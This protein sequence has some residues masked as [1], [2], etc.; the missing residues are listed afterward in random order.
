MTRTPLLWVVWGLIT[1]FGVGAVMAKLYVGGDRTVLLPDQTAGAH[2]QLEISCETCHTSD[3]FESQAT[4]RKDINKTC[5]TCHKDELKAAD[6][7]HPKKKF[8]NPRMAPYWEKIDGRFCTS[9]HVEHQPEITG[10]MMVTLPGDFCVACHS[11]G[12]QDIRVD[13]ESHAGLTFD[14]CASSGCHNYHD[15]RSIYEDFLVKHTDQPWLNAS[16]VI[17]AAALPT[18]PQPENAQAIEAYLASVTVTDADPKILH[19]WASTAHAAADVTCTTCHAPEDQ[20]W[21]DHPT[22]E[23]CADCHKPAA[24]TMALGKHGMRQHPEIAKPRDA[25]KTLKSLGWKD[26]PEA[27]ITAMNTYLNDPTPPAQMSTNDALVPVKEDAHG[28]D[29]TCS[30]CHSPHKEEPQHTAVTACLSCH[31]DQHST[32]YPDSPH[33]AL[34]QAEMLGD[35][36]PGSGVTCAT[37]HMPQTEKKG[38]AVTNHNQNDTLR[39]NEKMIR[40]VC[41]DCHGLGFAIDALADPAL[42]ANNFS[43]Q[44][45]AHIES[46]DW[47]IRRVEPS[48]QGANQ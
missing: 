47:A 6:D 44:P 24:K 20:A 45:I 15:N 41:L 25:K 27:L 35:G 42:I 34:W 18:A 12:E 37:C 39:P 11:E 43:G 1:L 3:A 19:D 31:D 7:S 33:F 17:A 46:I 4:V 23:V 5:T 10:P 13:R 22:Q 36:V 40:A 8:T 28:L 16:P 48:G 21:T 32:S 29:V 38:L 26:A 30:S 9:C 2:H 14:T